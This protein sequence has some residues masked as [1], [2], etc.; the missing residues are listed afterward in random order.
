M[1]G[2]VWFRVSALLSALWIAAALVEPPGLHA[3]PMHD[4]GLTAVQDAGGPAAHDAAAHD[5]AAHDHAP[6]GEGHDGHDSNQCL[7]IGE[8]AGA[9]TGLAAVPEAGATSRVV[10]IAVALP[11]RPAHAPFTRGGLVLPFANGPPRTS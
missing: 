2:R 10:R 9:S 1:R 7:C 8:C 5:A 3:C 4:G 11:T 6:A